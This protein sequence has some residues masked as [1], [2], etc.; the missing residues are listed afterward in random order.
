MQMAITSRLHVQERVRSLHQE[1]CRLAA[2]VHPSPHVVDAVATGLNS[3]NNRH[4]CL[5]LLHSLAAVMQVE[6]AQHEYCKDMW[7]KDTWDTCAKRLTHATLD[8]LD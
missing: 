5:C 7:C 4:V 8:R 6:A 2:D 3:K 1:L